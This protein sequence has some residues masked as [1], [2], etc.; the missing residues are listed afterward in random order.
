VL[1]ARILNVDDDDAQRRLIAGYFGGRGYEVVDA[2]S[3]AE[4]QL[5]FRDVNPELVVLDYLLPDAT[6]LDVLAALREIDGEVP[7]VMVTGHGD[8]ELA[9]EAVRAG[10]ESF[11][12]KPVTMSALETIVERALDGRRARRRQRAGRAA[13]DRRRIDPFLG[14]SEALRALARDAEIAARAESPVLLVGETGSGK[15][16]LARWLHD[17]G[18]RGEEA[19]VDLNCAGLSR[20]LLESELFGHARGAFTGAVAAKTGLI[21]TAHRGTLFLD[22]IGDLD[23]AIQPKLLKV[24]EEKRFRRLGETHERRAD[25]RLIAATNR[26]LDQAMQEGR[27]RSDL[28]YRLSTFV[29]RL[30]PLRERPED[31]PPLAADLVERLGDE[32]GRRAEIAPAAMAALR[33]HE[34]PGNVREL[35]NVLERAALVARDGTI[36]PADLHLDGGRAAGNEHR[37]T[38]APPAAESADGDLTLAAA[39]R[40]AFERALRAANGNVARAS[41]LLGVPR[42][43]LYGKLKEHRLTPAEFAGEGG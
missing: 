34:W 12:L 3:G 29:L 41:K 10:A 14:G 28:Y 23:P 1:R 38:G 32:L 19:F 35:R 31:I 37:S 42:S 21:E 20:E 18:P 15:G 24:L 30:P 9:V 27:F 26:F 43:T 8:V 39:E 6:G 17:H 16:V 36:E 2:A 13:W 7:V 5:K 22:E 4:A 40:R 33:R 25:T 11:L